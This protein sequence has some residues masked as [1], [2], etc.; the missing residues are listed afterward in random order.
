[1]RRCSFCIRQFLPPAP[2]AVLLNQRPGLGKF[3]V[4]IDPLIP[5]PGSPFQLHTSHQPGAVVMDIGQIQRHRPPLG[6]L[7]GLVEV[8]ADSGA[9]TY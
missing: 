6:N 4:R 9:V 1:M 3:R 2:V 7:L 8:A 5:L